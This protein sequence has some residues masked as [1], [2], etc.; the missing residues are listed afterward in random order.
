MAGLDTMTASRATA[1]LAPEANFPALAAHT[2][3]TGPSLVLLH[4]GVGS[5]AHWVRNIDALAAKYRVTAFDLPGYGVSPDV[6]RA[7]TT[8]AYIDWVCRAITTAA[9]DGCHLAGF[10]FGGA[11]AARVAAQPGTRI[12]RLSLLGTGGFGVPVGRVLPLAK[13]P[14][15]ESGAQ[16]RRA[17]AAANLGQWMLSSAPSADDPIVD[18]QMANIDRTRFDSRRISLKAT[19]LDDL[20]H[21]AAPVQLI[22]GAADKLAYPSVQSRVDSCR[23]VRADIRI[24][25]IPDGGHWIQYEQA[26]AVNRLLMEFHGA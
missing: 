15:P 23:E 6:P 3:G 5:S 2:E 4:G 26:V 10:S 13:I 12:I 11:L 16:A 20:A 7:M 19:L 9:P 21:I 24:A 8:D 1:D 25:L 18:M 22:W 17:A 14:G